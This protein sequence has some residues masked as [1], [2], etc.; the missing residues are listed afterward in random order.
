MD[1]STFAAF[2]GLSTTPISLESLLTFLLCFFHMGLLHS[3]LK[4]YISAIVTHQTL[5]LLGYSLILL[6]RNF[7]RASKIFTLLSVLHFHNGLYKQCSM[8]SPALLSN[9]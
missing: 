5:T 9:Q 8:L 4:V 7:L 6:S 2:K 3:T 1:F